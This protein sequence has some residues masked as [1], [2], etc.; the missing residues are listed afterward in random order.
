MLTGLEKK[1]GRIFLMLILSQNCCFSNYTY[2]I[3]K[4][5]FLWFLSIWRIHPE[6]ISINGIRTNTICTQSIRSK[7]VR[8]SVY[9][10][11]LIQD[12]NWQ[13]RRLR[14]VLRVFSS[15]PVVTKYISLW[16]MFAWICPIN[17][18]PTVMNDFIPHFFTSLPASHSIHKTG[19]LKNSRVIC[20]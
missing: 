17:A 16:L 15:R 12:I 3:K 10:E 8:S 14:E 1:I 7:P 19:V 20:L 4:A 13:V 2:I 5:I 9:H 18:I 6:P 11:V